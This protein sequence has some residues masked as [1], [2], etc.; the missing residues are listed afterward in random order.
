MSGLPTSWDEYWAEMETYWGPGLRSAYEAVAEDAEWAKRER[1]RQIDSGQLRVGGAGN[2]YATFHWGDQA[3][4][5]I[6]PGRYV[7]LE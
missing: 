4:R 5:V 6:R 1:K 7:G 2:W 3:W